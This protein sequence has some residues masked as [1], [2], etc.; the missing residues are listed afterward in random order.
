MLE[1]KIKQ[2]MK[3]QNYEVW[4]SLGCTKEEQKFTQPV[5][6]SVFIDF[7]DNLNGCYSDLLTEAVDYVSVT[8]AI[9]QIA[10]NKSYHLIEHL[11]HEIILQLIQ[12]LKKQNIKCRLKVDMQKLRVPVENLKDGVIFSCETIL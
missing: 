4:V 7:I 9:K 12:D 11:C 10:L 5:N 2:A 3:I 1:C 8:Q 6:V